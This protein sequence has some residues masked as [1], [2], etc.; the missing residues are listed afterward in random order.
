MLEWV[1]SAICSVFG[2]VWYVSE[3]SK[4]SH[5]RRCDATRPARF[6]AVWQRVI[7]KRAKRL[8]VSLEEAA[9]PPQGK[10]LYLRAAEAEATRRGVPVKTVLDEDFKLINEALYDFTDYE[11]FGSQI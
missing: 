4:Q 10:P 11:D 6:E 3:D 7:A 8:G 9:K 5:C 1:P 2:H